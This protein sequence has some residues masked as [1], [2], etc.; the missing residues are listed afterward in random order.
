MKFEINLSPCAFDHDGWSNLERY[1]ELGLPS[2][3]SADRAAGGEWI[4]PDEY[5]WTPDSFFWAVKF[6]SADLLAEIREKTGGSFYSL[7]LRQQCELVGIEYLSKHPRDMSETIGR[8]SYVD[9][10]ESFS[11]DFFKSSGW[12]GEMFEGSTIQ[13]LSFWARKILEKKGVRYN[14]FY[15]GDLLFAD[16]SSKGIF[17]R[18]SISE[19]ELSVINEV[20]SILNIEKISEIHST[21]VKNVKKFPLPRNVTPDV[22]D[23]VHLESVWSGISNEIFKRILLRQILGF[24]GLGWPDLTLQKNGNL[25]FVEVKQADDKFT[26]RQAYWLR[27][28]ARPLGLNMSVLHV[29]H[30]L[31]N[32]PLC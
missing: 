11:L 3:W 5:F 30:S 28:F 16:K 18:S 10:V 1:K 31:K 26:H 13:M 2:E 19:P 6:M 20:L 4:A 9:S 32:Q 27:N 21:W 15:Y 23:I 29:T 25:K 24:N 22:L 7:S 8:R 17:R 14:G 12:S